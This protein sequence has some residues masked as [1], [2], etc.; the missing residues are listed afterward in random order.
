MHNLESTN[1]Y[2]LP[3]QQI[4]QFVFFIQSKIYN[5]SIENSSKDIHYFQSFLASSYAIKLFVVREVTET[6]NY[7]QNESNCLNSSQKLYLAL[8]LDINEVVDSFG[9]TN[10]ISKLNSRCINFILYLCLRPE[11]EGK[12]QIRKNQFI[13]NHKVQH[14]IQNLGSKLCST[15]FTKNLYVF[16][17]ML[18]PTNINLDNILKK[19]STITIFQKHIEMILTSNE[20][21]FVFFSKVDIS[22]GRLDIKNLHQLLSYII[23]FTFEENLIESNSVLSASS[24]YF[25]QNNIIFFSDNLSSI[26]SVIDN[27]Y[28]LCQKLGLE[29][30]MKKTRIISKQQSFSFLGFEILPRF[31]IVKSKI[32][33]QVLLNSSKEENKLILSKIRYILRSRHLDG[34]TRAKTNMPLSKAISLI[35][36]LIINWKCYYLGLIPSSTLD[37]MDKLLNEKIYR[38]Y[39]KRLKKNRV[40]HWNKRCIQIVNNKKRIAQETYILELFRDPS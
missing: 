15:K 27:S 7:Q 6:K 39:I 20:E 29:Y 21:L 13:F 26:S 25:Y 11:W 35:N 38:W 22:K 5:S 9:S 19:L 16:I 1:W 34:K 32:H 14:V 8:T 36:P 24:F 4:E 31:L 30:D 23:M 17:G 18:K 33:N 12:L 10:E 28:I 3:W 2:L 40:T 37:K